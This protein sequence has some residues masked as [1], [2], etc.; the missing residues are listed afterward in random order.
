MGFRWVGPTLTAHPSTGSLKYRSRRADDRDHRNL[1]AGMD[2]IA[3]AD[4]LRWG[5]FPLGEECL[6]RPAL[7]HQCDVRDRLES[8]HQFIVLSAFSL[9]SFPG[10]IAGV[11]SGLPLGFVG[12]FP[13]GP[14][15]E[16][17]IAGLL[18][19]SQSGLTSGGFS[20]FRR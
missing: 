20:G 8:S 16:L 1:G 7:L 15:S 14:L 2:D 5:S 3:F 4:I 18:L 13:R 6:D 12:G 10:G 17:R 9:P 19:G 11:A